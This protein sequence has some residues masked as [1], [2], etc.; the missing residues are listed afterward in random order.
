MRL[1]DVLESRRHA[2]CTVSVDGTVLAAVTSM[3]AAGTTACVVIGEGGP[4]GIFTA[5]DLM[6]CVQEGGLLVDMPVRQVMSQSP[7]VAGVDDQALAAADH[8]M[9]RGVHQLPVMDGGAVAGVLRL[10]DLAAAVIDGLQGERLTLEEYIADLHA[11]RD[12]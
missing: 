8:M 12:D 2:V 4:V 7:L 11:A 3:R 9:R 6:R 1:R 10:A 5:G